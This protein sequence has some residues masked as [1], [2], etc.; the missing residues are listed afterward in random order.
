MSHP[1]EPIEPLWF[2]GEP[3]TER[4]SL[5][6]ALAGNW[7]KAADLLSHG[8]A[9][10]WLRQFP[11]DRDREE[12]DDLLARCLATDRFSVDAKL[13]HL[14]NWLDP[15]IPATYRGEE[16]KPRRLHDLAT[17][18]RAQGDPG[19]GLIDALWRERLLPEFERFPNGSE[20]QQ[21]HD[22]WSELHASFN[23]L[24]ATATLP[25]AAQTAISALPVNAALLQL[26]TDHGEL[27]EHLTRVSEACRA[28]LPERVDWFE[29][30]ASENRDDPVR[31]LILCELFPV[32][33]KDAERHG[34]VPPSKPTAQGDDPWQVKR[35]T[36]RG[37]ATLPALL[38][39]AL[40]AGLLHAAWSATGSLLVGLH[41]G[42]RS[43]APEPISEMFD[44]AWSIQVLVEGALCVRLGA[45][46]DKD[47]WAL[48]GI[49][50]RLR[51]TLD[52]TAEMISD[53]S[54]GCCCLAVAAV[55]IMWV[56]VSTTV[57]TSGLAAMLAVAGVLVHLYWT[58]GR[59]YRWHQGHK[60]SML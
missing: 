18:A 57:L 14:L 8:I 40:G 16:L 35:H 51:P 21:I 1:A 24:S 44:T 32:A 13:I 6:A 31:V 22:R 11:S 29:S 23:R 7:D 17:S 39:L 3:Y 59:W 45:D 33:S 58:A 19:R 4:T 30:L 41:F 36:I 15:G 54:G 46:Y 2:L 43:V 37:F 60:N 28:S 53:T 49:T 10:D 50:R 38:W 42:S 12:P 25:S 34:R 5:A 20:L 9:W 26:A 52:F 47:W 48:R 27:I 56:L 55:T